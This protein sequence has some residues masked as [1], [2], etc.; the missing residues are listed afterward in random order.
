MDDMRRI[1]DRIL[2]Q[3]N[4]LVTIVGPFDEDAVRQLRRVVGYGD[5]GSS[6]RCGGAYGR[7]DVPGDRSR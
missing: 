7:R 3:M 6:A 5:A 1:I 4:H 2:G